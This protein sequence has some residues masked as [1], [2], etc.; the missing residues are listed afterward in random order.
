M[1]GTSSKSHKSSLAILERKLTESEEDTLTDFAITGYEKCKLKLSDSEIKEHQEEIISKVRRLCDKLGELYPVFAVGDILPNGSYFNG[2]KIIYPDECDLLLVFKHIS[3]GNDVYI[4]SDLNNRVNVKIYNKSLKKQIKEITPLLS[5]GGIVGK[6]KLTY[7][8]KYL[9]QSAIHTCL[10]QLEG[11]H[12]V[13]KRRLGLT[14]SEWDCLNRLR[15]LHQEGSTSLYKDIIESY[16][17]PDKLKDRCRNGTYDP[18]LSPDTVELDKL[19]HGPCVRIRLGGGKYTTDIDLGFC[20][21]DGRHLIL[22]YN[23]GDTFMNDETQWTQSV[24]NSKHKLDKQHNKLLMLLKLLILECHLVPDSS[25][26]SSH[27]LKTLVLH[28][29]AKCSS[30]ERSLGGCLCIVAHHVFEFYEMK[31]ED[32]YLWIYDSEKKLSDVDFPGA[33]DVQTGRAFGRRTENYWIMP[34]VL[35]VVIRALRSGC[36]TGEEALN[37]DRWLIISELWKNKEKSGFVKEYSRKCKIQSQKIDELI[38]RFYSK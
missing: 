2:S 19:I 29:Q 8:I 1:G 25:T 18:N 7:H 15:L 4:K 30:S 14:S 22:P 11:I 27:A 34:V 10:S 38:T 6:Y 21:E 26:Y 9:L 20:I 3:V 35:Y 12:Y 36:C 16:K 37:V 28:H 5:L 23:D 32:Q 33:A 17:I 31:E 24:Y 13:G